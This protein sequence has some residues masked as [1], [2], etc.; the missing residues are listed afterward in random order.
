MF[1]VLNA[2]GTEGTPPALK[3]VGIHPELGSPLPLELTFTDE[4]ANTVSLKNYFDGNRPVLLALVYYECP[5]LCNH[6]L[7]GTV[8][9]FKKLD[10]TVGKEFKFLAVSIDSRETPTLALKKKENYLKGGHFLTGK[11]ENIRSLAKAVGFNYYY[12][13]EIQQY[14]HAAGLFV[15]TPQGKLARVLNGIQFSPRDLRLALLEASQGKMGTVVDRLLLL[16]YR[17]D[18]HA[19][20]YV[21]FANNLMRGGGAVTLLALGY[22][23]F[24]M[25]RKTA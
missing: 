17:Y 2:H 7:D 11:E 22:L 5:N 9:T 16:C 10:W 20:K 25:G 8:E 23:I 15:F 13:E 18:P 1:Y 24:K 21:L 14:A 6:L 4:T 12:D 19:S 3:G